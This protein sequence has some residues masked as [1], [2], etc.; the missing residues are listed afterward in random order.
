MA[1]SGKFIVPDPDPSW[2][3]G[4]MA[5]QSLAS[6]GTV[7]G[8]PMKRPWVMVLFVL[9]GGVP[10]ACGSSGARAD[11][12]PD[13]DA[14]EVETET[15]G[16]DADDA[17]VDGADGGDAPS[18]I[19]LP[20]D[21]APPVLLFGG[22]TTLTGAGRTACSHQET[23]SGGGDRWCAFRR[24]GAQAGS[25]E[26]WVMDVSAAA[27]GATPPCDGT[28]SGCLLLTTAL[29]QS[30]GNDFEGDTLIFY[31]D[32]APTL[33]TSDAY[34]GPVYAW[35]PGWSRARRLAS[36]ASLCV[37]HRSAPVAACLD[38][39]TGKPDNP[40]D[41]Q[42]RVGVV[43]DVSDAELPA[44]PGRWAFASDG[45][46][47]WQVAF[48]PDGE[49][50][51]IS[52]GNILGQS[53]STIPTRDVATATLRDH[54]L[55]GIQLWNLSND[56]K[57]IYFFRG[58][59]P[60]ATLGIAD[61][62]AGTGEQVLATNVMDFIPL[63]RGPKD[64]ALAVR[65]RDGANGSAVRL[66]R[67]RDHPET[68]T[69]LFTLK[70]TL[71]G[72]AIA[73]DLRYAA[74]VDGAFRG[75]AI[76]AESLAS[77][78]FNPH[79]SPEVS[80]VGFTDDSSYVY[81]SETRPFGFRDGI[82]APPDRCGEQVRYARS[83]EFVSPIGHRGLIYGDELDESDRTVTLKY[84]GLAP[85]RDE[86]ARGGVRV[87]TRVTNPVTLVAGAGAP[88]DLHVVYRAEATA[89]RPGGIYMFGPVPF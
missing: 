41:V 75:N 77:C 55:D 3:R 86:A 68:A 7:A 40:N 70:G 61:F 47:L 33:K 12:A 62:P 56:G 39:P 16:S 15:D 6:R 20:A 65:V 48:S 29:W 8:R 57:K 25:V 46:S 84:V 67:D 81:W 60:D 78:A 5:F 85:G 1:G 53:L 63:G 72:L 45:S 44:L 19:P 51:A 14:P 82:L 43:A 38:D 58:Q 31:A 23:A 54:V 37:G 71:E 59:K 80:N 35:R 52:V 26:L 13:G 34:V 28:S 36:N 11:A 79:P 74:W 2:R 24:K 4:V 87:H 30:Y 9:V 22:E 66:L 50:F 76:H 27:R 83:L 73:P 21:V 88:T 17:T 18:G 69:T 42:L 89:S 49:T 10:L 64:L 32:A